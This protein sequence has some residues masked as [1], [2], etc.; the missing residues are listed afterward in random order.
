MEREYVVPLRRE[1]LKSPRYKRTNKAVKA[2]REF[3]SKHMKSENVSIGKFLNLKLWENGIKN[4]PHK[5]TVIAVKD[6]EGKVTVE[7]K[8]VPKVRQK[9]NKRLARIEKSEG[10]KVEAEKEAKKETPKKAEPKKEAKTEK[11]EAPKAD[12]PSQKD[13]SDK[14]KKE[15]AN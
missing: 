4:P 3:I 10:K 5:V 9:V 15:S 8:E 2:L 13:D 12:K 11:P 14:P 6:D 7:L 1:S